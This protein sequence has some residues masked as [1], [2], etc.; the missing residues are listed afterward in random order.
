MGCCEYC[1]CNDAD[2][3]DL[4]EE[5]FREGEDHEMIFTSQSSCGDRRYVCGPESQSDRVL[6]SAV[7]MRDK[8]AKAVGCESASMEIEIDTT[9]GEFSCCFDLSAFDLDAV[10][11]AYNEALNA[12]AVEHTAEVVD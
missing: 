3:G 12:W 1:G 5:C 2:V 11:V 8:I 4:C 10:T 7:N 6:A 9:G